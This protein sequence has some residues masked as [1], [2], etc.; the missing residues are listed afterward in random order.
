MYASKKGMHPPS[1]SASPLTHE[2]PPSPPFTL[3]PLH[4]LIYTPPPQF[5]ARRTT[6]RALCLRRMHP[7]GMH[8]PP[9]SDSLLTHE[10]RHHC[11]FMLPCHLPSVNNTPPQPPFN[12]CH[13]PRTA[14]A[15]MHPLVNGPPPPQSNT[16]HLPCAAP[17]TY[18]P[19]TYASPKRYAPPPESASP[20]THTCH[21]RT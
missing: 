4:W 6:S 17:A 8:P 5:N 21:V 2:T 14:P 16:G 11:P 18:A 15:H 1:M 10:S 19:D 3:P 20:L 12:T 9:K 13:L 7:K